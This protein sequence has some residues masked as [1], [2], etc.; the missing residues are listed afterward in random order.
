[1]VGDP[2]DD[3]KQ[4]HDERGNLLSRIAALARSSCAK[5]IGRKPKKL[6]IELP[7]QMPM[8]SSI[9]F[10]MAIHTEVTCSAAFAWLISIRQ[11]LGPGTTRIDAPQWEGG[12]N[13]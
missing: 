9:L 6:T 5:A 11:K 3:H 13:R 2:A 7:T 1:M 8:V 12:S 10:F 4:R